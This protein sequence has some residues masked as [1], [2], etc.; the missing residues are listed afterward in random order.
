MKLL[1]LDLGRKTG[2]AHGMA[3][4]VPESGTVVLRKPGENN[5]LALGALAR[6]L[7]DHVK[8]HG[9]PDLILAEHWMS[10]QAQPSG[11]AVEDALRLNGVVH[12]IAGVYG[13]NVTEPYP[14]TIRSQVCGA[15]Y[16][17]K[18]ADG[19]RDTK[20]LV[21]RTMVLLG[22]IPSDCID[23]DRADA[24]AGFAF[25]EANFARKAPSNLILTG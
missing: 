6:W 20:G 11:A 24:C 9:K 18:R 2:F 23:E 25:L 7:R 15:A 13:I 12:A 4:T 16:G 17:P 1:S 8:R 21:I 22:Y 14:A 10:P 19:S 5:A 3:G